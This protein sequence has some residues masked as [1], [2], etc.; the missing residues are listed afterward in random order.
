MVIKEGTCI[1]Q[2]YECLKVDLWYNVNWYIKMG[3]THDSTANA[4]NTI[5]SSLSLWW[6]LRQSVVKQDNTAWCLHCQGKGNNSHQV[7][8]QVDLGTPYQCNFTPWRCQYLLSSSDETMGDI[9]ELSLTTS[10]IVLAWPTHKHHHVKPEHPHGLKS[11]VFKPNLLAE[12]C[13]SLESLHAGTEITKHT[14][15]HDF[16]KCN[17]FFLCI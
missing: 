1:Y 17:P 7:D 13:W 10:W 8:C 15:F 5:L 12:E 6:I 9:K 14:K 3:K 2:E 11:V 16:R 4:S